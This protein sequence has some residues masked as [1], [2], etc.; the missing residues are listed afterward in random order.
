M[1]TSETVSKKTSTKKIVIIAGAAVL[2]A[3]LLYWGYTAFVPRSNP[4]E[5]LFEQTTMSAHQ[6][7]ESLKKEGVDYLENARMQTISRQAQQA[8]LGL[9]TCCILF[10]EDK[11]SF[12]EFVNCQNSFNDFE[13]GLDRVNSLITEI[14][15]SQKDDQK[16]LVAYKSDRLLQ[17][18]QSLEVHYNKFQGRIEHYAQRSPEM[19]AELGAM[20]QTSATIE[21]EPNNSYNQATPVSAGQISA[22]LLEADKKDFFKFEVPSGSIL[23]L[24]FTPDEAAEPM[25]VSL[26][27]AERHELWSLSA[28]APGVTKSTELIMNSGSGGNFFIMVSQ[29][30]GDYQI[31]L[32]LQGQ[33]DAGSGS[34]AADQIARA[35]EIKP[36]RTYPGQLGGFDTEDWYQFQITPGYILN[37]AFTPD[38]EAEAMNFSL[39]NFERNEIWNFEKV[40]PGVT[41]SRRVITSTLSGGRYYLSVYDGKGAYTVEISAESQNDA[42]SG[43]DAGDQLTKA[44]VVQPGRSY[45][46][47]LGGL[48]EEDWY[49][50]EIS[51]GAVLEFTFIPQAEGNSMIFALYNSERKEVWHSGEVPPGVARSGRLLMNSTSGGPYYLKTYRGGGVYQLA[52]HTKKQNDAGSG[53]DAGDRKARAFEISSGQTFTGELGGLD[54]EDW[55]AFEPQKGEKLKFTCDREGE[56]MRLSLRTLEQG[57]VGYAAEIFPGMTKSFEIPE[58]VDPPYLIRIFDGEGRYSIE[59]K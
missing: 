30:K 58:D 49:R 12:E 10:H 44:A 41:K 4:C 47:E 1:N 15:A 55:Y 46:G 39:R 14:Q 24:E 37:L 23:R 36:H 28:V 52:L 27:D 25:N 26:H 16:E 43:T 18:L 45:S 42:D 3:G 9:K 20:S 38:S 29:G 17:T 5:S 19:K 11:I 34:D 13:T 21:T 57:A 7:I 59:I 33:N 51:N 8:A 48:D 22:G 31:T 56:L 35:L 40:T 53:T 54:E 32:T 50:F 2:I 6:K